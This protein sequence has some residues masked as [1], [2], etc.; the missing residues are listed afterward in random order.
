MLVST[1]ISFLNVPVTQVG[2]TGQPRAED[3][4]KRLAIFANEREVERQVLFDLL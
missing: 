4:L 3:R 2:E 1:D